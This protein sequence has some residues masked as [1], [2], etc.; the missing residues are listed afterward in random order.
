MK[1]KGAFLLFASLFFVKLASAQL[2]VSQTGT[3]A[4]WVQNVLLGPGISV[5]N[6]SYTGSSLSIGTF[7]TGNT[8]TNLGFASGMILS[9]GKVTDAPG[10]NNSGGKSTN[11]GGGGDA[12]LAALINTTVSNV[13]DAAVLEFD[14]VPVADTVKFNYVFGSEEYDEFVGS[15]YNDVFGFFVSGLNP[16]GGTYSNVNIA[17]IPGTT[18]PVSINNVNNGSSNSGPCSNC[19]YYNH[20]YGQSIQYDGLTSVLT[21]W[22]KV[23]PCYT[24]HIK[25]AIADVGDHV[26]DSGVFLQANSFMSNSIII[27]QSTSSAIDTSAVEGCN[28]AIITFRI[29]HPVAT[30]TIINYLALGTATN[31]VDYNNIGTQ[32]VIPAGQ[33]SVNLIIHPIIDGITEGYET[34]MLVVN[35]S[36]CTYDTVY[37]YIKDNSFVV[38]VLPPDTSLCDTSSITINSTVTGGYSPYS[39]LWSTGDTTPSITVSP[40]ATTTYSLKATDLCNNDSTVSMLVVVSKPDFAIKGDS[41]CSG[42]QAHLQIIPNGLLSYLWSTGA[43]GSSISVSPSTTTSYNVRI[44]DTI[45]CFTDT[46]STAFIFPSPLATVSPDDIMCQGNY[47]FIKAGGGQHYLWSTGD[48]SKTIKVSPLQTTA[49]TVTVYNS[50]NC[51]DT[52]SV[53]VNVIPAPKAS[54]HTTADTL[55]KGNTATLTAS[56][57]SI[58]YW[59]TTGDTSP[60]IVVRPSTNS[61]YYL[62]VTNTLSGVKCSDTASVSLIVKRCN[63]IYVPS[64]FTPDGDGLN[65][66]FGV[67]GIFENIE[68]FEMVIFNRWGEVVFK[69][70]DINTK[71]TGDYKGSPAPVGVYS[72]IIKVTESLT[73]PYKLTGTVTLIR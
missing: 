18:T 50:G 60:S 38:P 35:T 65:D 64:A 66:A 63:R 54:I 2:T 5:S 3:V 58:Y 62:M 70:T 21:A 14:F 56:G 45:G 16:Y 22:I 25:I 72:F 39:Y 37:I 31:G 71:W 20:N 40:A 73:E 13:H 42:E 26:Y 49:Y 47:T 8:P 36:A 11:T 7:S 51:K 53:T 30:N 61:S 10:P 1:I 29:P 33:D 28:D 24:Y 55:C 41:V 46:S 19:A 17:L 34:V 15:N 4:Q 23:I 27:D 67:E 6:I 68:A 57:G 48:T 12:N 69:T 59:S 52:A 32:A 9:S 43:T 44:T